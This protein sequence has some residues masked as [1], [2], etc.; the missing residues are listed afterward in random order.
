MHFPRSNKPRTENG[1]GIESPHVFD[2]ISRMTIPMGHSPVR[3][4]PVHEGP[5]S[6][7]QC[8]GY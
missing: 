7:L 8:D 2:N 1:I 4:Y 6:I 5:T 3:F